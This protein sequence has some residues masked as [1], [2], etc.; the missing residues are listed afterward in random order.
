MKVKELIEKLKKVKNQDARVDIYVPYI[1]ENDTSSDY[2]CSKFEIHNSHDDSY[3]ELYCEE[4]IKF[5]LKNND[6]ALVPTNQKSDKYTIEDYLSFA[7]GF[8]Y[9]QD[10]KDG[11]IK[12]YKSDKEIKESMKSWNLK[13]FENHFGIRYKN[14]L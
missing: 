5:W 4:D 8:D 6:L 13:D 12:G 2:D 14:Q 9:S 3:I 1:L 7:D 11:N 10:I